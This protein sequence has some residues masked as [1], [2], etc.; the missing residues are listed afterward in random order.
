[1]HNSFFRILN[2]SLKTFS[3]S[4]QYDFLASTINCMKTKIENMWKKIVIE[5]NL[6]KEFKNIN[7]YVRC[8]LQ[9]MDYVFY[10]VLVMK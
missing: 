6:N 8:V 4:V 10:P 3:V 1:M 7:V 9:W 5:N 2:H